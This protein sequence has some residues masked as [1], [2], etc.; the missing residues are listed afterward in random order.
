MVILFVV[1]HLVLLP[2]NFSEE[3]TDEDDYTLYINYE[4][5]GSTSEYS[6]FIEGETLESD[7][8]NNYTAVV[9]VNE[10]SKPITT[11]PMGFGSLFTVSQGS[12]F[13][14]GF[15]V[16]ND[17]QTI[18]LD[19]YGVTPT[20]KVGF[21]VTESFITSDQDSSLLDNS[22]GSSNFAA[23]GADRLQ[24]VLTLVK[25]ELDGQDPN[26]IQLA[27][28]IEGNLIGKPDQTIK[29]SWL[30]D[31][32]AKRTSDES[33]DYIVTEFPDQLLE[34]H[35]ETN[36]DGL[37]DPDDNLT[38]PPIPNGD[39]QERLTFD[40]ADDKYVLKIDEGLAYV[41][42]Y[43]VGYKNPILIYGNKAREKHFVP[44]SITLIDRGYNITE[45]RP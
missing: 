30:Y 3:V 38:Y 39:S 7:T 31:I 22:Q 8:P 5:S 35:N 41:Q 37:F 45:S 19:K 9:G 21:L 28:I 44:D 42:G 27:D 34:Y 20:Y 1:S 16:R 18:T 29:W 33:G 12:Y 14:D 4:S 43:E 40:E 25:R 10:I 17:A 6:T 36:I 15:F 2:V 32:L 26:F 23:P 13:V 11:P 24:I